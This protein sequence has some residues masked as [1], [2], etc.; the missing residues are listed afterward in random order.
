MSK[1]P[2]TGG[3][4]CS[5]A[6]LWLSIVFVKASP[7]AGDAFTQTRLVST[8]GVSAGRPAEGP[9]F[10]FGLGMLLHIDHLDVGWSLHI[11]SRT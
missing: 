6:F 7:R 3:G 10:G 5:P 1:G 9:S 2:T 8:F 11:T 4:G